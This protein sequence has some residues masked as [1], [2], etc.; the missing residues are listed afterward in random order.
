MGRQPVV[1]HGAVDGVGV[2][3]DLE[4]GGEPGASL[5]YGNI[6]S[7]HVLQQP[8]PGLASGRLV[9]LGAQGELGLKLQRVGLGLGWAG[10]TSARS[11]ARED[12][13]PW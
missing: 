12:S 3:G 13:T 11:L 8:R 9:G 6:V 10:Q 5:A 1:S 7:E 4:P 2:G